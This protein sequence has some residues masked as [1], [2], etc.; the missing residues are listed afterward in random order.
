MRNRGSG[1]PVQT[2]GLRR[3]INATHYSLAG[4]RYAW[5]EEAAFR[6]ELM[7]A[8]PLVPAALILGNSG[9]ER[10]LLIGCLML[11]LLVEILNSAIEAVV[12]RVGTEHHS[13][14]GIAKDLG[15]AAV[16]LAMWNVLII[17]AVLLWPHA[18]DWVTGL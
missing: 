13:L 18:I 14:A 1:E 15:S 6:F 11:V 5:C 10:A 16:F 8:L 7:L 2:G 12:D 9:V 3:L 4:L 17:W